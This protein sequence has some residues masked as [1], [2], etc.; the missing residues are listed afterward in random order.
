MPGR[1]VRAT[2][3]LATAVAVS[4]PETCAALAVTEERCYR[5]GTPIRDFGAID[6]LAARESL[7][8]RPG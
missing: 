5:S 2:A 1:S 3:R 6:P 8:G 7:R 4:F